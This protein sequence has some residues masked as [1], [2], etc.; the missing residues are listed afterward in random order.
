MIM[1]MTQLGGFSE[2]QPRACDVGALDCSCDASD[3]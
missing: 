2:V 1:S 3:M